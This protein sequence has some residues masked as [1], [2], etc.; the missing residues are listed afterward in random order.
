MR[1][2]I[3]W[4]NIELGYQIRFWIHGTNVFLWRAIVGGLPLAMT[5]KRRHVSNG[6]CL[7]CTVVD[8]DVGHRFITC[9]VAK[10]VWVMISQ[11]WVSIT[12]NILSPSKWVFM[13]DNAMPTPY[14]LRY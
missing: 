2:T 8:E 6:K 11:I 13:E 3:S 7:F 9:P 4:L 10:V 12:R 14:Y 5:L 1:C